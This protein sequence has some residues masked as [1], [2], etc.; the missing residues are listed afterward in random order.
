MTIKH[1]VI[2]G[3]GATG[4][5]TYG[6]AA[7]LARA[8][9]WSLANIESIYG[10]SIGGYMG[11]IFSL[12]YDWEWLDDYFIKRPW[13]KVITSSTISLIDIYAEKG[14]INEHFFT[15][16]I[17]PL[18]K[19]KDLTEN[20]TLE[21]LYTFNHIDIHLYT[22][23]INSLKF[24]KIDLSYKT[25]PKLSIIKALRMTMAFPILFQ[26]IFDGE[27]CYIDGGILNNFP[28]NDC[29]AQTKCNREDIL[30]FKNIWTN[31]NNKKISEKSSMVD[32]LLM[33][34]RKMQ[35]EID[36]ESLQEEVK[37]TV[38]CVVEELSDVSKWIEALSCEEM[39][40]KFIDKGG[41]HAKLFLAYIKMPE[42]N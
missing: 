22:T 33:L 21:E 11:V 32:F 34:M 23:N 18:L 25:H 24:E 40:R 35:I 1:L 3:G 19:A 30:A 10:C 7:Y 8:N 5:L 12:G 2:S 39:R 16:A 6:A 15:E 38:Q 20:T 37:Y 27:A 31:D 4:F 36:T 9:F 29:L 14:L 42:P 13:N 17:V 41:V 28:L 26:P